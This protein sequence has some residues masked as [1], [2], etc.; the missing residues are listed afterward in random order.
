MTL[1]NGRRALVTGASAGLG[2]AIARELTLSG[3][4]L[5]VSSRS[6]ERIAQASARI[7]ADLRGLDPRPG[8][9][10]R[11]A[12][13]AIAADVTAGTAAADLA[14]AARERLGGLDVLV[15]NAGGPPPGDFADL[16]DAAWQ[17]AFRLILL[18]P[19]RLIRA[20]LPMLRE[21]GSGRILLCSSMSGVQPVARLILS[22]VLRP[23]L[24]GLAKHLGGELAGDGILVNAVAPGY[25]ATERS[26]EVMQAI[27]AG[28]GRP[29][30]E[31]ERERVG[32]V[33]LARQGD[34]EELGRLAAFLLSTENSYL[35]GQ[36]IV[37]DGGLTTA[38]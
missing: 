22:N 10:G 12:P 19:I 3:A 23:G 31:I 17:E 30:E 26:R 2:F 15:C 4:R 7:A 38:P 24:M 25:F 34:P 5:L 28:R 35:T 14:R 32:E 37:I 18:S 20:C 6:T 29:C 11:H 33:P 21:S 36:T 9:D 1:L 8:V 13:V 16:D 27:A